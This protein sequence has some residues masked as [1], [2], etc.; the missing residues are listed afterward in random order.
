MTG[1]EARLISEK[2][3]ELREARKIGETAGDEQ[4]GAG[5]EAEL[6][7]EEESGTGPLGGLFDDFDTAAPGAVRD[8]IEAIVENFGST[9]KTANTRDQ[10]LKTLQKRI[11]A[12]ELVCGA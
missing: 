10:R 7:K 3:R 9:G 6:N 8:A 11:E 2:A 4:K 1:Y 12:A 5:L